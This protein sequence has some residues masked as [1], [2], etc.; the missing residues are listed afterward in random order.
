MD[1]KPHGQTAK[2]PTIHKSPWPEFAPSQHWQTP[3][4]WP[5]GE[6]RCRLSSYRTYDCILPSALLFPLTLSCRI[7]FRSESYYWDWVHAF[8]YI[9]LKRNRRKLMA[10]TL[11]SVMTRVRIADKSRFSFKV[12]YCGTYVR[13]FSLGELRNYTASGTPPYTTVLIDNTYLQ[14]IYAVLHC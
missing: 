8:I 9:R 4:C 12:S 5:W 2:R 6:T 13:D 10:S 14:I 1:N 11:W 3:L 7:V